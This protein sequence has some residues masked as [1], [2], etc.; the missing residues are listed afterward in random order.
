MPAGPAHPVTSDQ[1]GVLCHSAGAVGMVARCVT[2]SGPA[3]LVV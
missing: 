1:F 2:A 3:T